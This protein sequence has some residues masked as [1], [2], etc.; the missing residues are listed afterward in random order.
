MTIMKSILHKIKFATVVVMTL[1][2]VTSCDALLDDDVTDFGTGPN[3]VGFG[4]GSMDVNV[5][6]GSG[7]TETG[8]PVSVI[9][10][11]SEFMEETVTVNWSVDASST[12][13][14]GVHYE[15]PAT[16]GTVELTSENDYYSEIPL[17][18]LTDGL[19]APN[20]ETLVL[21]VTEFSTSDENVVVNEKT[22]QI[23]VNLN[24]LCH[25]E[26]AGE[27]IHVESGLTVNVEELGIARFKVD[28]LAPFTAQGYPQASFIFTMDCDRVIT[29]VDFPDFTNTMDGSGTV[30]DDGTITF[31]D[32]SISGIGSI[33]DFTIELK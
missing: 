9:G 14:A 5:G 21:T 27:Y 15:L 33:P 4:E 3:F 18:V 8:I 7:V 28:N 17:S 32:M 23:I 25:E 31:T 11:T 29:I 20:E 10:P 22:E 26:L 1:S 24:V 19:L 13:E 2:L 16:S 6:E 12:A 30:N